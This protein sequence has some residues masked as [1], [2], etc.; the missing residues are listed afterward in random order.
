MAIKGKA[1][2]DIEKT[3][4]VPFKKVKYNVADGSFFGL[5]ARLEHWYGLL[6]YTIESRQ[7][8]LAALG[9]EVD[10]LVNGDKAMEEYAAREDGIR[11]TIDTFERE[12]EVR[13]D[14]LLEFAKLGLDP[15]HPLG[16]NAEVGLRDMIL[17]RA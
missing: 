4:W 8:S 5:W 13:Q 17:R 16:T 11:D 1:T 7:S 2:S 10:D 15:E 6:A 12:F 9:D 14:T 3:M